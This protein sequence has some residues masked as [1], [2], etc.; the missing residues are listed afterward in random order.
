M[1]QL[2]TWIY[3]TLKHSNSLYTA[4]FGVIFGIIDLKKKIFWCNHFYW[5]TL[6]LSTFSSTTFFFYLWSSHFFSSL[7]QHLNK[8][9]EDSHP[10]VLHLQNHFPLLP[11]QVWLEAAAVDS[12][13]RNHRRRIEVHQCNTHT[14][15]LSSAKYFSLSLYNKF[16]PLT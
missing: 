2:L 15:Y 3:A 16:F 9:T 11:V 4:L 5:S 8:Q 12:S 10:Q 6:R 14:S 1:Y 7:L 13:E